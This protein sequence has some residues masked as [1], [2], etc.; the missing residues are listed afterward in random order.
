MSAGDTSNFLFAFSQWNTLIII[1]SHIWNTEQRWCAWETLHKETEYNKLFNS[2]P[3]GVYDL[4]ENEFAW[5]HGLVP[6]KDTIDYLTTELIKLGFV[7]NPLITTN[8]R[9]NP[10]H[11]LGFRR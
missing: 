6:D 11:L 10:S 3:Q 1:D 2:L 5:E 8:A 9:P 4:T 7:H